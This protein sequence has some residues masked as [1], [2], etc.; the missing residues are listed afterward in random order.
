VDTNSDN[1]GNTT[2]KNATG[3]VA[4]NQ[5]IF[6]NEIQEIPEEHKI[7]KL[8]RITEKSAPMSK[9]HHTPKLK[10]K[11]HRIREQSQDVLGYGNQGSQMLDSNLPHGLSH[12]LTDKRVRKSKINTRLNKNDIQERL[13]DPMAGGKSFVLPALNSTRNLN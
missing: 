12:W 7:S 6:K 3:R 4:M 9:G 2:P 5:V 11:L 13:L 10:R 1:L 8:T